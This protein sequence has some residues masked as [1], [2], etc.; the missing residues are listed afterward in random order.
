[1]HISAG[2]HPPCPPLTATPRYGARAPSAAR[3]PPLGEG[4]TRPT[5]A[6]CSA[7]PPRPVMP[8]A[9]DL[10]ISLGQDSPMR[11]P[12][13]WMRMSAPGRGERALR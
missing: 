5:R 2:V 3:A 8:F 12:M 4:H 1:M 6:T 9:V 7:T 10:H 11:P 13:V